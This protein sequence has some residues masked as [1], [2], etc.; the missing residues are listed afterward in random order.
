MDARTQ[1]EIKDRVHAAVESVD[2][3]DLRHRLTHYSRSGLP[4]GFTLPNA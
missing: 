4:A 3:A 2:R 1:Q